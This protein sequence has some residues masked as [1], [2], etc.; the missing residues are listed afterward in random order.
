[1]PETSQ[2]NLQKVMDTILQYIQQVQ[3]GSITIVIQDRKVVQVERN[4][5]VRLR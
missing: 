5:K 4:E 1:M 2:R 3:Y